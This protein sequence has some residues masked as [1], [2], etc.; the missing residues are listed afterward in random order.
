MKY[1]T[2]F[3]T[4]EAIQDVLDVLQNHGAEVVGLTNQ[5]VTFSISE[6]SE[7]D[8][9]VAI[10]AIRNDLIDEAG[11]SVEVA[12]PTAVVESE[13]PDDVTLVGL[14]NSLKASNKDEAEKIVKE[15][16]SVHTAIEDKLKR[17]AIDHQLYI[18]LGDYGYGRSIDGTYWNDS[19]CEWETSN[20][21][22]WQS[23]SWSC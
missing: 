1:T 7:Y 19:G 23:S 2:S 11:I 4:P 5:L 17:L 20:E 10:Q 8:L 15:L 6:D 9:G 12:K 3:K 16:K 18:S 21:P 13:T 14:V 22:E